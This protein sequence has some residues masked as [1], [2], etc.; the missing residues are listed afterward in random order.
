[1]AF[2]PLTR[3]RLE[4][5]VTAGDWKTEHQARIAHEESERLERKQHELL[6]QRSERNTP[7]ERIRIWERRHGLTLPRAKN[8][9]LL[10]I[11]A[12]G[13]NLALHQVSEE[14]QRRLAGAK[15]EAAVTPPAV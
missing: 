11:V 5:P 15:T 4:P 3:D 9:R 2:D 7:A 10:A 1:M 12:A 13:T 14:Q 6:E 8:H